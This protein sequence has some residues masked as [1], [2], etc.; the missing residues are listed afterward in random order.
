[1]NLYRRS[2]SVL[3]ARWKQLLTASVSAALHALFAAALVWMVGPLLMTLFDVESSVAPDSTI[4]RMHTPGS[5]QPST[6]PGGGQIAELSSGV[7]RLREAM[8][9]TITDLT[10]AETRRGKLVNFCWLILIVVIAKN[11]FLYLQGFFMAYVQQSVMR[12]FRDDLFKK[13]QRLSLDY[14]HSRRT[15]QIISRVTNDVIVLNESIDIGF[16]RLV[17]DG[18]LVILFSAFL[19]ILSWKLTLLAMIVL[20]VVFWFIYV[21]GKKLRKYSERSQERMADVNSVLEESVSNVRIVRAFAMEKFEIG[22]FLNATYR[23][24]RDLL[25]MTRIRHLASPV[26]DTLATLAG[27]AI[28]LFAGSRII[29]GTGELDVG[30]FMTFVLAMFSMIKPVKSLSQIHIK[31]QEGMAAASRIFEVMDTEEKIKDRPG[32]VEANGFDGSI[33]Y[34]RVSFRYNPDEPVLQDIS[35]EVKKGEIVALVGPSG[36]GKSTLFDLLPRYYDPQEGTIRIDGHDIR[37]L[38]INSLRG[39]M[40]IV[41]QETYLFNDT[42]RNNIAYG[43][44]GI[45]D[46]KVREAARMANA[47]D[48][49]NEFRE[50]YSTIVGNRGVKLSGG[51]RQRISIARALLKNP[52]ILIFDEATSSLDTESEILVQQAID[53]LIKGRTTLVIAHR[54]STIK[55]ADRIMVLDNGRIVQ[56]GSHNDLIAQ[57]GLYKRLYEMQFQ[58]ELR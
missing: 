8:K 18:L 13:Y 38:T 21:V 45:P 10:D 51:Q 57:G 43:L 29:E 39:L 17:T 55:N 24:F 54:L 4:T 25:R 37:D 5:E 14:F 44:N 48:F 34:D 50:G 56:S 41:T 2:F 49:V 46:E 32:A 36:A 11:V 28:L 52:Q 53:H 7:E 26:N 42:I 33:V 20:P 31:L 35:F 30:D 22:K 9:A 19:V 27:I 40:G 23:Y 16:N 58:D 47:D 12:Q 1:M 3:K 15:G 6:L